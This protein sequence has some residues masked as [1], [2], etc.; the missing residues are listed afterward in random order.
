VYFLELLSNKAPFI[1]K[2]DM[3]KAFD[4]VDWGFLRGVLNTLGFYATWL[5]WIMVCVMPVTCSVRFNGQLL[6]S[7]VPT[8]GIRQGDLFSPY[9]FIYVADALSVVLHDAIDRGTIQEFKFVEEAHEFHIFSL[10]MT[11]FFSF[12]KS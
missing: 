4:L 1:E 10:Q 3:A 6:D 7:F 9:L 8:H 12:E 11:A 5:N 2:V